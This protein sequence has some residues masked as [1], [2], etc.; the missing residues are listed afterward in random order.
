MIIAV[1]PYTLLSGRF[2]FCER[3]LPS[4]WSGVGVR[5][6]GGFY[7]ADA[8][9]KLLPS[10]LRSEY[11]RRRRVFATDRTRLLLMSRNSFNGD[12]LS[13]SHTQQ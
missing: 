10:S 3:C 13:R 6:E 8:A 9:A 4:G 7:S 11:R 1:D 5:Q 2:D 12:K